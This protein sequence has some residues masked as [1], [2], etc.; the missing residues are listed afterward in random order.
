[1]I[2]VVGPDAPARDIAESIQDSGAIE[3]RRGDAEAVLAGRPEVVVS[4]G[5]A[6]ASSLVHAGLDV[7]LL[8]V[9]AGAGIESVARERVGPLLSERTASGLHTREWPVLEANHGGEERGRGL[10]DAMLVTSEPARISEYAVATDAWVERFRADGVVV[11]TPAGSAGY[12]RAVGG[13]VVDAETGG[14]SVVP[15]A[16][17]ALRST[18]RVA[19]GDATLSISVERDEGDVSLLVDGRERGLVPPGD[20]VRVE[21]GGT[22]ETVV[23]P[24]G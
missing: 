14:L 4:I 8:P 19:D 3:A 21:V 7:P 16:A 18:T 1:M 13:P 5:E 11:S 22:V 20:A 15:V 23:D 10:F 17:F 9:E 12:G 6:A 2:G 24:T